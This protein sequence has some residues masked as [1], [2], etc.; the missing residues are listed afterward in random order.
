MAATTR[1]LSSY[2]LRLAWLSAL[3]LVLALALLSID[4]LRRV[5]QER[6]LELQTQASRAATAVEAL[7]Q[8]RI[9]GLQGLLALASADVHAPSLAVWYRHAQAYDQ[10]FDSPV[11]LAYPN[12]RMLLHSRKRLGESLPLAPIPAGRNALQE[13][14]TSGQ[15]AV[16]DVVQGPIL[17]QSIVAIVVPMLDP[18][19]DLVWLSVIATDQFAPLLRSLHLPAGWQAALVDGTGRVMA[20]T[21]SQSS[22]PDSAIRHALPISPTSWKLV[23]QVD[24][25]TFH[26]PQLQLAGVL[27]ITLLLT[28]GTSVH[29]ARHYSGLLNAARHRLRYRVDTDGSDSAKPPIRITEVEQA[30]AELERLDAAQHTAQENERRRVA[31]DLHD[32]LQQDL[33]R[34]QIDLALTLQN[35]QQAAPSPVTEAAGKFAHQAHDTVQSVIRD[36]DGIVNDL[37]PRV[38]DDLGIKAALEQ[39]VDQFRRSTRIDIELEVFGAA[40]TLDALPQPVGT[41]LYRIAQECLNN[42]RKHAQAGFVHV[43]LDASEPGGLTL[44]VSDDG[45]GIGPGSEV[46]LNSHGMRGMAERVGALGGRLRIEPGHGLGMERGTTVV[47]QLPLR[48]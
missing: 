17:G 41:C 44:R 34:L 29:L 22:R 39:L 27:L 38:L 47:A 3:P 20:Q 21:E 13:A 31:Q 15:P 28:L 1:P 36:L 18:K 11:L 26:A 30:R 14:V 37:R 10:T 32:G 42:V 9:E 46:K 8:R 35:L 23:I 45:V 40:A 19:P 24:Y 2:L 16:G 6:Q 33:A 4:A 48:T 12:R 43:L 7:L 5:H 25:W